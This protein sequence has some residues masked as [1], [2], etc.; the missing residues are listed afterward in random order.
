M[1]PKAKLIIGIDNKEQ[2]KKIIKNENIFYNRADIMEVLKM[3]E[4]Y[5]SKIWDTRNWIDLH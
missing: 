5:S 2:F 4:K 1:L 3:G